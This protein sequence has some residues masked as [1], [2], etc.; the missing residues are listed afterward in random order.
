MTA[1]IQLLEVIA[2]IDLLNEF[3]YGGL[4]VE[5]EI[6]RLKKMEKDRE[7]VIDLNICFGLDCFRPQS[8]ADLGRFSC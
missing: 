1:V 3:K 7:A 2:N 4:V 6:D 5:E 8:P